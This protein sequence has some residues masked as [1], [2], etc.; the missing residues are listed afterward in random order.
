MIEA[1]RPN[2]R[3][4]GVTLVELMVA[5]AMTSVI[6]L[7]ATQTY[8]GFIRDDAMRRKVTEVQGGTRFTLDT[9][10]REFRHAS[11]STGTGRIWT[12]SGLNRVARP[13][14]QIFAN[15][16]GRGTLDLSSSSTGHPRASTDALL[17]V[18]AVGGERSATVGEITSATAGMPR[19]FRVTTTSTTANGSVHTLDPGE[20]ILVGDYQD[21]SWAV[22]DTVNAGPQLTVRADLRLPGAQVPRLPAGALVRR[23]RAR[24]YYVDTLNQLVRLDLGVPRAPTA[25]S[26]IIGREVL[27]TGIE[28]L[29]IGCEMATPAGALAAQT[30]VL[31]VGHAIRTE[32]GAAFAFGASGG[33]MFQA[34]D[35]SAAGAV[36][37]LR[38]IVFNVVARSEK[39]LVGSAAGDPRIAINGVTLGDTASAY[40]RR[41]YQL[42]VGVRN[43]S[44]GDL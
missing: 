42:A 43:V 33:P 41:A 17:V 31:A 1:T 39:P 30:A 37:N 18:E 19:T 11:L 34:D 5:A 16:A 14:V 6:A 7:L 35:S 12:A 36:S 13:A 2:P 20:A 3:P 27:A 28:N 40:V 22:V 4:S 26:E 32:S 29:Q 25:T 15:V 8:I 24:L 21:A 23:A 38:T 9:L 10:T 44:L